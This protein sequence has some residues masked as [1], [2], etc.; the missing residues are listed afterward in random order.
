MDFDD[1]RPFHGAAPMVLAMM[2]DLL[3]LALDACYSCYN[4]KNPFIEINGRT[5]GR[6]HLPSQKDR[7]MG[8]N[9]E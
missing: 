4:E 3:K 5:D 6:R 9:S 8:K 7:G 1:A 2:V